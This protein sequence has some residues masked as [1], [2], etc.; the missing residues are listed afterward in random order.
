MMDTKI[1]IVDDHHVVLEGIRRTLVKEQGLVIVGETVDG[2]DIIQL[3]E[4]LKPDIVTMDIRMPVMDGLEATRAIMSLNPIPIVVISSSVSDKELQITF[5]AIEAGA[6]TVIEK[7]RGLTHPEFEAMRAEMVNTVRAMS[8]VKVIRRRVKTEPAELV[9]S[10]ATIPVH[11]GAYTLLAIG[12]STG[13]PQALQ[14]V[15]SSLPADF[16]LPI[17]IVQHISPGFITGMIEW[18][19]SCMP[20]KI[21]LAEDNQQLRPGNIYF[22]PDESHLTVVRDNGNLLTKLTKDKPLNGFRPSATPLMESVAEAC[23][24]NAIGCILTGM[25]DDGA[26]GLL[27]LHQKK[28][29]TFVQDETSSVVF[30]MPGA[31]LAIGAA[32]SIVKLDEIA[33]HLLDLVK[34]NHSANER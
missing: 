18:L 23:G 9:R 22:G 28:A 15:L 7:P 8:E 5:R 31:A 27:K 34:N 3:C 4:K 16:P 11:E 33:S 10:V 25:G 24:D 30:G 13:G 32:K 6:M 19:Q 14:Q 1:L 20:L 26:A 2:R 17:V 21:N 29:Y 12:C